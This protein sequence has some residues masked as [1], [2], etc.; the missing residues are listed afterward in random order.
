V[1]GSCSG[2]S[3]ASIMPQTLTFHIPVG[4]TGLVRIS[5]GTAGSVIVTQMGL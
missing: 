2:V 1:L 3:F 4:C 5:G